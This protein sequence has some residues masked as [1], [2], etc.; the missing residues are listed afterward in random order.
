LEKA[1]PHIDYIFALTQWHKKDIQ[2]RFPFCEDEKFFIARNGVNQKLF[3][4]KVAKVPG[5][6]IYSST[7]FRG[8]EILADVFPEIKRRV[9]HATLHVFSSFGVYGDNYAKHNEQWEWLYANLRNMDGVKYSESIRQKDLAVEQMEAELLAY[10]NIFQETSCL[11]VMECATA[12]TPSVTSNLAALQ[13]TVEDDMGIKIDGNPYSKEYKAKFVDEVVELLN[14]KEKWKKY[15]DA[16]LSKDLTWSTIA[17]EWLRMFF[18][19]DVDS[20]RKV[21]NINTEAYW[22]NVY[23]KEVDMETSGRNDDKRFKYIL[24]VLSDIENP[25]ILD[26]ACGTGEFTRYTRKR[27]PN[28]EIWGSDFSMVAIDHCRQLDRTIFYANHP[29]LNDEFE[30]KYFDIITAQHVL[31]HLDN[32]KEIIEHARGLLKDDGI[33]VIALPL[34]DEEYHE[35]QKVYTVED[36]QELLADFDCDVDITKRIIKEKRYKDGRPFEEVLAFVKFRGN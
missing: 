19:E 8:L 16:C 32:P 28:V 3:Q 5:R 33:L 17:K 34:N 2:E 18:G 11:T 4:N 14:N 27:H 6:L 30:K 7:P 24:D 13:E 15:S 9:P 21:G 25:T 35:H 29:L 1:Y 20:I 23:A 36:V 10:P 12:G 26:M 31:E 22:D